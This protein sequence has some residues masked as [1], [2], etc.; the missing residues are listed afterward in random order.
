MLGVLLTMA[1]LHWVVLVTPGA[2]FLLVGQLAASGR[3]SAACAAALGITT[4]TLT[5]AALA[6]AGIGIV[7]SAH[8]I[9]RQAFQ[10]A[11]GAYL[12]HLAVKMYR[13]NGAPAGTGAGVLSHLAAF[14]V[15]FL[16]NV[17]NPKTAL[18]FGSVFASTLPAQ[19]SL[20]LVA[21][22]VGL[23]YANALAWHL[24]L[25]VAF[26]QPRIQAAY[27]L[28]RRRLN[29]LS[30]LLVGAFG[31]KLIASTLQELRARVA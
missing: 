10:V 23:V 5:W 25:A 22:A 27:E 19:P 26:S 3:R 7:F 18:F 13:S 12:L 20:G 9:A 31:M 30:G 11:G 28:R 24:F 21:S 1:V 16:N 14:R 2:N 17:L 4:V 8:P 6:V 29:Q 15:G